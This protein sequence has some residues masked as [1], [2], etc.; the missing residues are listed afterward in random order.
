MIEASRGQSGAQRRFSVHLAAVG[1]AVLVAGCTVSPTQGGGEKL[2]P[3][4]TLPADAGVRHRVALLVPSSGPNGAVGQSLANGATLA[5]METGT[6][7]LRL[8]TYDTA[9]GAKA[10]AQQAIA[11]GAKLILGPV[12]REDIEEVSEQARAAH[13]PV[14]ALG[15]D[16]T[17]AGDNVFVMGAVPGQSVARVV[18][19]AHGRGVQRFAALVPVGHYGERVSNAM[20]ASVRAEGGALVGMENYDRKPGA[21]AAAV[22][23]LRAHGGFDA[24]LVGDTPRFGAQA[25]G[26]LKAGGPKVRLLGTE[27]WNGDAMVAHS[28]ALVGA[29]FASPTD[30]YYRGFASRYTARFGMA[31]Y[32]VA[33]LGYDAVLL[34]SRAA[35]EW[36][37][38]APFPTARLYDRAGF[39]G[40]DG[41]F[42]FGSS[43][44][45]ERALE[46]REVRA[47]GPVVV[48]PAPSQFSE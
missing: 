48:S 37:A 27:L 17:L 45:V 32:R 19:Y 15:T 41:N 21:M 28:P 13:V 6:T 9:K 38:G 29:W 1:A 26:L 47:N 44:V 35:R 34:A 40:V 39:I 20:L 25:A 36:A 10:A 30:A 31:P 42:R 14:I 3:P 46:V 16:T 12:A 4:Q 43:D 2:P 18:H 5:L 7:K 33:P 8:T 24:V 11:D 22:R 23:R